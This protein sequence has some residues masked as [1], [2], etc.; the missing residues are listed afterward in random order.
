MVRTAALSKVERK[1]MAVLKHQAGAKGF[2]TATVVVVGQT[3]LVSTSEEVVV[4]AAAG[5]A[6]A[7]SATVKVARGRCARPGCTRKSALRCVVCQQRFCDPNLHPECT[8]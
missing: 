2:P 5:G 3:V 6:A 7:G 4:P 8:H 1:A